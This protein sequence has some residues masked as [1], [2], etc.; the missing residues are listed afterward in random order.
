MLDNCVTMGRSMGHGMSSGSNH[1][2]PQRM[3]GAV[4]TSRSGM[5]GSRPLNRRRN[6]ALSA[7]ISALWTGGKFTAAMVI[8]SWMQRPLSPVRFR[9]RGSSQS[10]GRLFRQRLRRC[11]RL[12]RSQG[13]CY[14]N[15]RLP[16]RSAGCDKSLPPLLRLH[17]LRWGRRRMTAA[18]N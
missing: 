16:R 14:P 13:G 17:R 4:S 2:T 8:Q 3:M 6:F 18:Q 10:R 9:Q 1:S 7:P 11:H 12:L 15:R 5:S